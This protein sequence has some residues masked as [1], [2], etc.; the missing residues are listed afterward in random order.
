MW[1]WK[2]SSSKHRVTTDPPNLEVFK[3]DNAQGLRTF[4]YIV[5]GFRLHC[6][7]RKLFDTCKGTR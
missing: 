3:I 6:R 2:L 4:F 1:T 5:W 7:E